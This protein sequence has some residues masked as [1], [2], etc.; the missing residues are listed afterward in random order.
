M[1]NR[2]F[3]F[4]P[5]SDYAGLNAHLYYVIQHCKFCI[6]V[7]SGE[8]ELMLCT[9]IHAGLSTQLS[10]ILLSLLNIIYFGLGLFMHI[11]IKY[12]LQVYD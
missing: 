12:F 6:V 5:A 10:Y 2:K 9:D 4:N 8:L 1:S 11:L 3:M 7:D